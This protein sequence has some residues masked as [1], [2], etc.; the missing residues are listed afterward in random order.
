[1]RNGFPILR[2]EL[3]DV[4]ARN[5]KQR[6]ALD[7]T[8]QRI[9]ASQ[10]HSVEVDLHMSAVEPPDVL[11]HGTTD[12][13]LASILDVGLRRMARHHVHLSE[14]A[15]TALTVGGRRGRP[16]VLVVDAKGMHEDGYSFYVSDNGVWLVDEVPAERLTVTRTEE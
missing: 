5:D 4:I 11:Y 1:L 15:E 14:N 9:R 2:E 10:G 16:V 12:K 7:D 13:V 3:D 6:F 8:G